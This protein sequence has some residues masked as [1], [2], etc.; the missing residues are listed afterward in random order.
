MP[1]GILLWVLSSYIFKTIADFGNVCGNVPN[2]IQRKTDMNQKGT[3]I[4]LQRTKGKVLL[5]VSNQ[6]RDKTSININF[7]KYE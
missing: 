6:K 1:I 3:I 7:K 5:A 2:K 4:Y